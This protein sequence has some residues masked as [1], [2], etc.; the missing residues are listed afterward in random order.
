MANIQNAQIPVALRAGRP[1]DSSA[2]SRICFEA[3]ERIA[4]QHNFPPDFPSVDVA[5]GLIH[6][7]V[8]APGLLQRCCGNGRR[9][10]RQQLP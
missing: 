6:D 9:N 7:A 5:T 1:T 4:R 10:C 2:C 8:V 3:F